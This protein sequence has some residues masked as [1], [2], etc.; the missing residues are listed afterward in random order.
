MYSEFLNVL[1]IDH[2]VQIDC[3]FQNIL[4][5]LKYMELQVVAQSLEKYYIV[6]SVE[7][8]CFNC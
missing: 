6:S 2:H 4:S 3:L 8:L 5:S 7:S 1:S